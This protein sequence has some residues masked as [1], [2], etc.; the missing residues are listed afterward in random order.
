[1]R[2]V[3][4]SL[5]ALLSIV[6]GASAQE[7][8]IAEEV[9]AIVGNAPIMMSELSAWTEQ[10]IQR[11]KEQGAT[12]KLK[13]QEEALEMLLIKKLLTMQAK[14]DS[15]D[16]GMSAG[17]RVQAE[18]DKMVEKAGS[19]K[20]LEKIYGKPIFS[21]RSD[22]ERELVEEQLSREMEYKIGSKIT[23]THKE[24]EDFTN[25][26]PVDSLPL[27]PKRYSYA[28]IVKI[29]PATDERKYEIRQ[30]LLEYRQRILAGEKLAVLAR[31]YSQDYS[32]K[33][34]GGE[35]IQQID[36]YVAPFAEAIRSLKP[37][38][39]SEIVET[40]F[41][42]HVIE[43]ISNSNG[44]GHVRHIL[45]KPE[46]TIEETERVVTELDSLSQAITNNEITFSNAAFRYSD[47]VETRLNGG[48]AFN[49]K[50]YYATG[51]VRNATTLYDQDELD[52]SD[53]R[54]LNRMKVGEVSAPYQAL[55]EKG[56]VVYK[57]VY[58]KELIPTHP[59]NI[60]EDYTLLESAA[61]EHK[62]EQVMEDWI[63]DAIGR[64]YIYISPA[65]C[66]YKLS[67][68]AWIKRSDVCSRIE[69]K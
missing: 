48:L 7:K 1:M 13:P 61:V 4:I 24:V 23:L 38:Q 46:F 12:S 66:D 33:N 57:I 30:R 53:Y 63:K 17:D 26:F 20:A 39:I 29:P 3:S 43:L 21:I 69:N 18:V 16:K 34:A 8:V 15:L 49:K 32:S 14:L 67:R 11:T 65:Y 64:M 10:V 58:L 25:S 31:L 22:F 36:G 28:Q 68:D 47:D 19:V 37:G 27:T 9:V 45:L 62:K 51:I 41:G 6:F 44:M 2:K 5:L 59:A 42:F 56:N 54:M 52:A 55:D 40:E 60:Y 50:G 35:M